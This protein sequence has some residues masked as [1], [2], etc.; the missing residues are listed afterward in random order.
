MCESFCVFSTLIP[1]LVVGRLSKSATLANLYLKLAP[2]CFCM[3]VSM[4]SARKHAHTDDFQARCAYSMSLWLL[5]V[6]EE[7]KRKEK[8]K[9]ICWTRQSCWYWPAVDRPD[10]IIFSARSGFP[11]LQIANALL[12]ATTKAR[13]Q[14]FKPEEAGK[15]L[16]SQILVYT[17]N[18]FTLYWRNKWQHCSSLLGWLLM[19]TGEQL[20][21][22]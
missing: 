8:K 3:Y 7:K 14:S 17:F 11:F 16:F 9:V 4:S 12:Y 22:L 20:W 13:V 1:L 6:S 10:F 21:N 18:T 15:D 19:I 5:C 2:L